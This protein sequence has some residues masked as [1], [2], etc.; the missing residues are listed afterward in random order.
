MTDGEIRLKLVKFERGDDEN[1]TVPMYAY[2]ITAADTGDVLGLIS[3]R[4]GYNEDIYYSGNI[5]Y[6]VQ[7]QHRGNRYAL[8]ACRLVLDLARRHGMESLII[9]CNPENLPSRR[10]CELLGARYTET[11]DLPEDNDMYVN[12]GE[13]QKCI[14]VMDL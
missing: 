11:V 13:R 12:D 5:G 4:V 14:F 8:R 9:T 1:G 7:E 10:T 6:Y 2:A 3:L